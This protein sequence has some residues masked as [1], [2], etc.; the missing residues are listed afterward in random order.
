MSAHPAAN[1]KA[2]LVGA[3]T[4]LFAA[5]GFHGT[6]IRDIAARAGV[7]VAAAN[8][9]FGS[10]KALYL[11]VLRERFA[12]VRARIA[13]QAALSPRGLGRMPRAALVE[14]LAARI[15]IMFDVMV[16]PPGL[17]GQLMLRE[18]SNP[19][20][21]FPV[22]VEEFIEPMVAEMSAIVGSLVPTLDAERVRRCV[23]S[24]A[25]QV[26]FYLVAKPAVQRLFGP[27]AYSKPWIR[28]V[29]DHILR[30]TLGGLGCLPERGRGRDAR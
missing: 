23:A 2:R 30:F 11:S 24:V 13:R 27:N 12:V 20:E 18:L 26:Q 7:N 28:D 15:R 4:E 9:H 6:K 14:L 17:H 1:T 21:A 5:H 19:S 25:G 10:K 29:T 22:V 8:Y 16:G 3:A